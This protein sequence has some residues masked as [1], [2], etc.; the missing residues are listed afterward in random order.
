MFVRIVVGS[1]GLVLLSACTLAGLADGGDAGSTG[2]YDVQMQEPDEGGHP[3]LSELCSV[4]PGHD[5]GLADTG[6]VHP[7]EDSGASDTG[8]HDAGDSGGPADAG[9]TIAWERQAGRNHTTSG[10]TASISLGGGALAGSIVVVTIFSNTVLTVSSISGGGVTEW[11]V[12]PNSNPEYGTMV[13]YWGV[14]SGGNADITVTFS[15]Q[16]TYVELYALE[17]AN[18]SGVDTYDT[19]TGTSATPTV[20]AMTLAGAGEV[21]VTQSWIQGGAVTAVAD[22]GF[23]DSYWPVSYGPGAFQSYDQL[24]AATSYTPESYTAPSGLWYSQAIAFKPGDAAGSVDAGGSGGAPGQDSGAQT[25]PGFTA[26]GAPSFAG[27]TWTAADLTNDE[28]FKNLDNWNY[29][30]SDDNASGSSG[31][32]YPWCATGSSPYWGSSEISS[33]S[34]WA[35]D[36]DVPGNVSQT[37]TGADA[38]LFSG[39]SPQTF[40]PNGWGVTFTAVPTGAKTWDTTSYGDITAHWTSGALNTYNHI[41]FPSGSHTSAYVQIRAQMMGYQGTNN[42]AWNA[43]WFLGQG[44]EQR[45][46]D[47][48]ETGVDGGNSSY[49]INSHLQSPEDSIESYTS[50][51]DLSAGYHIYAMEL[52]GGVVTIFLDNV[53]VGTTMS[54]TTGPYFLIMNGSIASGDSGFNEGPTSFVNMTMN[55][56]EVQVYQ[57]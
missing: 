27:S 4:S 1:V 33:S 36:Y 29:G 56:M 14:T 39:Y 13:T 22:N 47:L 43:L 18:A 12:G 32:Y 42:G 53:Q 50:A 37:S 11:N 45:E 21:I 16:I 34:T 38:S 48:Q 15:G 23:V 46:I 19:A 3:C 6:H 26:M 35:D 25:S 8:G 24:D 40:N 49:Q 41:S 9:S 30:I 54:G 2:G 7:S 20:P 51:D 55:V 28:T 10:T 52:S 44:N 5:A 17:V 31:G 57:Q